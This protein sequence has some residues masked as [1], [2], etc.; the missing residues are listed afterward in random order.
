MVARDP[1]EHPRVSTPLGLFFDLVLL[2]AVAAA[3][4]SR[5][6]PRS[7]RPARDRSRALADGVLRDLVG[8]DE[9]H[10]VRLRLRHRRRGL[11]APGPRRD[12]R[13]AGAR[14][15]RGRA[16]QDR[17]VLVVTL[18]YCIM[19]TSLVLVSSTA[20]PAAR[21]TAA[22]RPVVH[23]GWTSPIPRFPTA[24]APMLS[25]RRAGRWR[26]PQLP[27]GRCRSP[28]TGRVAAQANPRKASRPIVRPGCAAM[29]RTPSRTPGANDATLRLS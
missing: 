5:A 15:R 10:V 6:T 8:V 19:R 21:C 13:R 20:R 18:G 24:P 3:G 23:D 7:S 1:D 12:R 14:S 4:A 2:V 27:G 17:D 22:P 9:P 26:N 29:L 16:C 28:A 25:S 11:A